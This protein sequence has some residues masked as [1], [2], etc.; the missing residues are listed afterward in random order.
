MDEDMQALSAGDIETERLLES[1]SRARLSPDQATAAR[2]RARVMR[3]AWLTLPAAAAGA[4]V[5]TLDVEGHAAPLRL[6]NG[7]S[8]VLPG[9]RR[10]AAVLLAAGLAL[11]VVG[12]T[13]AAS[14]PGLPLYGARMW[15]EEQFLPT[16]AAAR[17][18]AELRRLEA[19][20]AE[21][22][23]AASRGDLGGAAAALAEYD[24]TAAEL[25]SI[26][27]LDQERLE[28]LEAI[29]ARH[30]A[31]LTAVAAQ[32]PDQA[33]TRIDDAINRAIDRANARLADLTDRVESVA[34]A[35]PS[36]NDKP[37]V[38]VN[39][40]DQP[41]AGTGS[42]SDPAATP[43]TNAPAPTEPAATNAPDKTPPAHG[44]GGGDGGNPGGGGEGG[45][46]GDGGASGASGGRSQES[47]P[48]DSSP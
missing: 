10:G 42:T 20:L 40:N 44:P 4:A 17:A 25:L 13:M 29:L 46:T 34:P 23:A 33:G 15:I 8:R 36:A 5:G 2:I 6:T 37:P 28:Q 48:G 38:T 12:G 18:D 27:G 26:E 43:A 31:V 11:G 16:T 1:Y 3:E 21:A 24:Q 30:L 45:Q 7:G 41:G 9:L 39:K 14:G 35:K 22:S 47:G 19:R 32:V